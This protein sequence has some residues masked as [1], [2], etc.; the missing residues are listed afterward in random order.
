MQEALGRNDFEAV[1]IIGHNMRGSG[2]GFGFPAI[3]D[4]GAG[5]EQAGD[6]GDVEAARNWVTQLSRDLDGINPPPH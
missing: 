6:D 3:T 5:L 2:G 4:F 1:I